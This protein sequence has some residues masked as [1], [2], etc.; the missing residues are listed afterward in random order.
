MHFAYSLKTQRVKIFFNRTALTELSL[1][2]PG[3]VDVGVS[4]DLL[5]DA[6]VVELVLPDAA[7]AGARDLRMLG[8]ALV[9]FVLQP[10]SPAT[11]KTSMRESGFPSLEHLTTSQLP[12]RKVRT[13]VCDPICVCQ[14]QS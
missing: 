3:A 2:G 7:Q 11:P 14:F 13:A 5:Q 1:R 10:V 9:D 6:N 4:S 8:V 12:A